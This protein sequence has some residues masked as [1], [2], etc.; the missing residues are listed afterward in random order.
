M[1]IMRVLQELFLLNECTR[2][3][4]NCVQSELYS[5]VKTLLL[6]VQG[7]PIPFDVFGPFVSSGQCPYPPW[8][9]IQWT[10]KQPREGACHTKEGIPMMPR[11][12]PEGETQAGNQPMRRGLGRRDYSSLKTAGA[13]TGIPDHSCPPLLPLPHP[14]PPLCTEP[15]GASKLTPGPGK[16]EGGR[17]GER[18]HLGNSRESVDRKTFRRV[19]GAIPT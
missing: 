2:A 18:C 10:A 19:D 15:W 8:R 14:P 9:T 11:A 4:R 13:R 12:K 7:S 3:N 1:L 6:L 17:G 16:E 5:C